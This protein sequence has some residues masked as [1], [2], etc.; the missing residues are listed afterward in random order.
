LLPFLTF[1]VT[2]TEKQGM[3]WISNS[4]GYP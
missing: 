3:W 4:Y 1:H 2:N